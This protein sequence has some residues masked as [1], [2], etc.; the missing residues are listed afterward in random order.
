MHGQLKLGLP[1]NPSAQKLSLFSAAYSAKN[2]L[3]PVL[4]TTIMP[5]VAAVALS[6]FTFEVDGLRTWQQVVL[7]IS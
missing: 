6:V 1:V 7:Q 3:F 5:D 2:G 4:S